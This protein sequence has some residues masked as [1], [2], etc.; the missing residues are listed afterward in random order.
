MRRPLQESPRQSPSASRPLVVSPRITQVLSPARTFPAW[1]RRSCFIE[2]IMGN[3]R[4]LWAG[5]IMW[6]LI[7]RGSPE[8]ES[9]EF[10]RVLVR[11]FTMN[12]FE[13]LV[14]HSDASYL[15]SQGQAGEEGTAQ[16]PAR[17]RGHVSMKHWPTPADKPWRS[18]G[19]S[20]AVD[21]GTR[22]SDHPVE[23]HYV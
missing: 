18:W 13:T 4:Q 15:V 8:L 14:L 11:R 2:T 20:R 22:S 7:C 9:A 10:Q 5:K 16:G 1:G 21:W 12:L 19:H 23:S 17:S 6:P 3:T